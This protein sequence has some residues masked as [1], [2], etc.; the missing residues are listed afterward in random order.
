VTTDERFERIEHFTAGIAEE[1]RK[2][3]DEYKAL[4][5]DTQRQINQLATGL[6]T[7]RSHVDD[8]AVETRIRFEELGDRIDKLA[9]E[10]RAQDKALG[11]RIDQMVSGIGQFITNQ[12]RDANPPN[13]K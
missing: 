10:S 8:L 11:E 13:Q 4:W 5:R 1:R 2:D 6:N 12:Q 7:L 9:A 3:R